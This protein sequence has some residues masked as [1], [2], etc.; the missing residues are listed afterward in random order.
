MHKVG[1]TVAKQVLTLTGEVKDLQIQI[2]KNN[3]LSEI[4]NFMTYWLCRSLV[5]I[6]YRAHII[7]HPII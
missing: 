5:I 7:I 4:V 1:E 3:S 2:H 6:L